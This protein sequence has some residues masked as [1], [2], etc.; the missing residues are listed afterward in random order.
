MCHY[1]FARLC[2][3][4]APSLPQATS[5]PLATYADEYDKD[6]DHKGRCCCNRSQNQQ[7]F[8]DC[9]SFS[10]ALSACLTLQI[11]EAMHSE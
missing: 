4:E 3:Q 11:C 9:L 2:T 5:L 6:G 7:I 1:T 10:S 8:V